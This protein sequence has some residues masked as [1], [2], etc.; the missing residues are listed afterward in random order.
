MKKA[1]FTCLFGEYDNLNPAP[2]YNGWDCFLFTDKEPVESKGWT[3]KIYEP[4]TDSRK[5]SRHY[6][7]L[8]HKYISEYDLVCYIDANMILAKEPPSRPIWSKHYSGRTLIQEAKQILTLKKEDK[9]IIDRQM[10]YYTRHRIRQFAPLMQNGFFVREHS[11]KMNQ[12]HDAWWEQ[13]NEFS[14]RDQLS[15]P[16][17]MSLTDIHV[18]GIVSHSEASRYYRIV[19]NHITNQRKRKPAVHHITSGRSD[20]NIGKAINDMIK[21]LPDEDWICYRDIDT[22]PMSHETF[23]KQCEE[24]AER[25]DFSLIGC[26]T[27][28]LGLE[29]QLYGGNISNNPD[30]LYHRE[31]AKELVEKHGSQ[32]KKVNGGIAGLMMLFSKETWS[33]VGGFEEGYIVHPNGNFFDYE[34]CRKVRGKGGKIGVADGIYLFHFYRFNSENPKISTKHLY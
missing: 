27:N 11:E 14:Y 30:I 24:I 16:F 12:L 20:K 2:S 7:I 28:R 32:V 9:T 18:Q 6:K 19:R 4:W 29:R 1:I 15:L 22:M 10:I 8:S 21:N 5:Q 26:I 31:I 23:F 17:V 25:G 3:V 34:F 13:V 33:M